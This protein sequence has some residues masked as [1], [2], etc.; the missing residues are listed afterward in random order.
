MSKT[1]RAL[2]RRDNFSRTE[3]IAFGAAHP[4]FEHSL[5]MTGFDSGIT[6]IT[7]QSSVTSWNTM[8]RGSWSTSVWVIASEVVSICSPSLLVRFNHF[9]L[10][11]SHGLPPLHMSSWGFET[12]SAANK[13]STHP[14]ED[15]YICETC[16]TPRSMTTFSRSAMSV[17]G[18]L[19]KVLAEVAEVGPGTV[20]ALVLSTV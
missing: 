16:S 19:L 13:Q 9:L 2:T 3:S 5:K 10:W 18:I 8:R 17:E 11:E 4:S 7:A 1:T 6:R 14:D 20:L 15:D 12:G